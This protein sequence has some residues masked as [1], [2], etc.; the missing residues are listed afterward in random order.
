MQ[1]T[2]CESYNTKVLKTLHPPHFYD[3]RTTLAAVTTTASGDSG[4]S[5]SASLEGITVDTVL[6]IAGSH[7]D[8]HMSSMGGQ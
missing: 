7:A 1:C 5:A 6:S 3:R 2:H 4:V 8:Q